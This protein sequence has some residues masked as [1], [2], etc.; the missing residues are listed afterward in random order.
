[1]PV[2]QAN[3]FRGRPTPSQQSATVTSVYL[4]TLTVIDVINSYFIDLK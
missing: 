3:P 4:V 2:M 1:M